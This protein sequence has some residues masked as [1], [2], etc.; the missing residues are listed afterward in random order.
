M[1]TKY[2]AETRGQVRCIASSVARV[3]LAEFKGLKTCK[4]MERLATES[5]KLAS[6]LEEKAKE[7]RE[8]AED[9]GYKDEK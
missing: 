4:D 7:L 1:L 6:W 8:C 2:Q 3:S 5:L 9:L